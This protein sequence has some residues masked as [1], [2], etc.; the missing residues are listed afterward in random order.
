MDPRPRP[1]PPPHAACAAFGAEHPAP[2]PGG[3]GT[4]Y[5]DDR[6]VLKPVFDVAEA[7]WLAGVLDELPDADDLRV[8]RPV[9][10]TSGAWVV[11]GWA[12]WQRLDGAPRAGAWDETLVVSRRFH[13]LVSGVPWS[14][15]LDRCDPWGVGHRVAWG[16]ESFD[17]P[18]GLRDVV[19]RLQSWKEPVTLSEQFIHADLAN[20]VLFHDALPPAVIDVSPA[21]RPARYADA[22][23]VVDAIGWDGAPSD[24]VAP[25]ADDEGVQLLLRATMFRLG[26]AV[27]LCDGDPDRLER[28]RIAYERVVDAIEQVAG[29]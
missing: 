8:I 19:E 22:I 23:I 7:E 18:D 25:L 12:A 1:L 2:L 21:W 3:Q 20:N 16:E 24:A 4:T 9:R 15:A 14:A 17:V 11:D 29:R 27:V 6:V 28:E 5:A 26:S 10:S 13:E